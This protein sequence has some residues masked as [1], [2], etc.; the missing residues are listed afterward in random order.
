MNSLDLLELIGK[1]DVNFV[2]A[3]I[4]H[5]KAPKRKF[6]FVKILAVAACLS[7]IIGGSLL[8]V[9]NMR[10]GSQD[11]VITDNTLVAYNGDATHIVIP[12]HV[13]KI[14][15]YAFSEGGNAAK[16]QSI[17]LGKKT[18]VVE[19]LA[20]DGCT[21][22]RSVSAHENGEIQIINGAVLSA[23]GKHFIYL[24]SNT[25][26]STYA[27]P[28]GVESIGSYA[29]VNSSIVELTFPES[30]TELH[31]SAVIF[32]DSLES[33]T[34]LG[35]KKI[36][37]GAFENNVSLQSVNAPMAER[38]ETSAF[39]GCRSLT[40]LASPKVQYI[41]DGAFAECVSLTNLSFEE[42][43]EIG[44]NA[45]YGCSSLHSLEIPNAEILGHGFISGTEVRALKL[46]HVVKLDDGTFSHK[47]A[48]WGEHDSTVEKF[49]TQ[50]QSSPISHIFVSSDTN[51]LLDDYILT[52][53][54][55]RS[56][57][58][59]ASVYKEPN[60]QTAPIDT[61]VDRDMICIAQS[62]EWY[63]II[64]GNEHAYVKKN[65]ITI[66]ETNVSTPTNVYGSFIYEIVADG[67]RITEYRGSGV[68]IV[69]PQTIYGKAVV[70]IA[71]G[72]F[73][74][75]PSA[76]SIKSI[77]APSVKRVGEHLVQQKYA[78]EAFSMPSLEEIPNAFFYNCIKLQT[79]EIPSAKKIGSKAFENCNFT[80]LYIPSANEIH[81]LALYASN[82]QTIHAYASS[83]AQSFADSNGFGFVDISND[84]IPEYPNMA[85]DPATL[86]YLSSNEEYASAYDRYGQLYLHIPDWNQYLKLPVYQAGAT[87]R[88]H[89]AGWYG[90]VGFAVAVSGT[91]QIT[92]K[93][94]LFA[95]QKDSK[96][97]KAYTLDL[98]SDTVINQLFVSFYDEQ[99][100][101]VFVSHGEQKYRISYFSTSDGG[102]TWEEHSTDVISPDYH[103]NPVTAKFADS[104]VGMIAFRYKTVEDLCRR[105][106]ITTDGGAS[107]T[108]IS[109]LPY[110]D[111]ITIDDGTE[112]QNL[113]KQ[114][115]LYILTVKVYDRK[116]GYYIE[117]TSLDGKEWLLVS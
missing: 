70:E 63:M 24:N 7:L 74:Y 50:S 27:V 8:A 53:L 39:S 98:K 85:I 83:A 66:E 87:Y 10:D 72:A 64:Y 75:S 2:A 14:S 73:T 1:L 56:S 17:A 11:F 41:G 15:D 6:S 5:K 40:S 67:V 42:L 77:S 4:E 99:N 29:F 16:I 28:E 107:W 91:D 34:L 58:A 92:N 22:L 90:D 61:V 71:S 109:S 79:V 23:D 94:E 108:L 54:L 78:L 117:F 26:Y 25:E 19:P 32:N 110:P 97:I 57:L 106:Y 80:E 76:K 113:Q 82:V 51:V 46:Y 62:D 60:G 45:F 9:L 65:D 105:T 47:M 103:S 95:F 86:T 20:F 18:S 81:E 59:G 3:G 21:N 30:V 12:D 55:G 111:S 104:N 43:K 37:A 38:I 69:I 114:G 49:A 35:L 88:L 93:I 89:A 100:G 116:G 101:T 84:Y 48:L 68:D 31:Q 96:S 13:I 102:Q 44:S 52:C 33:V 112:A 115:E 36:N